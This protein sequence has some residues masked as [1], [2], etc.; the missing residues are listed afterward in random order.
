MF[1]YDDNLCSLNENIYWALHLHRIQYQWTS[2]DGKV[3][4]TSLSSLSCLLWLKGS[5]TSSR[6]QEQEAEYD[7]SCM[8]YS[9]Q[10]S[11][12]EKEEKEEEKSHTLILLFNFHFED[13]F[14]DQPKTEIR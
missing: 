4:V 9:P 5:K 11:G 7:V 1:V 6:H 12:K 10:A 13:Y 8:R 14:Y 3:S 2:G